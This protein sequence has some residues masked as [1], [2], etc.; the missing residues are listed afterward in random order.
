[1][2]LP[3]TMPVLAHG[4]WDTIIVGGLLGFMMLG[5]V[6]AVLLMMGRAFNGWLGGGAGKHAAADENEK[7][8][9]P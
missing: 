6:G 5:V 1:M 2:S 7:D 3:G 9:E 4:G 8:P